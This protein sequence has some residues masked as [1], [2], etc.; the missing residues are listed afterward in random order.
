M[1]FIAASIMLFA[2][3]I[4]ILLTRKIEIRKT[5]YTNLFEY[6]ID[7]TN[8]EWAFAPKQVSFRMSKEDLLKEEQLSESAINRYDSSVIMNTE[9]IENVSR[10]LK[11]VPFVKRF[12]FEEEYGFQLQCLDYTFVVDKD[13][14]EE[15]CTLL[16]EQAQEYMP[17]PTFGTL[18]G[19]KNGQTV[20]WC[21]YAQKTNG[22]K[23][24]KSYVTVKVIDNYSVGGEFGVQLQIAVWHEYMTEYILNDCMDQ[25]KVDATHNKNFFEYAFE[26]E[27]LQISIVD[28]QI[29]KTY[30]HV[31][32]VSENVQELLFFTKKEFVKDTGFTDVEYS[33]IVHNED[34]EEVCEILYEQAQVYMQKSSIEDLEN[35]KSGIKTI[36]NLDAMEKRVEIISSD[37]YGLILG[38]KEIKIHLLY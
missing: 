21:E 10:T 9:I 2:I 33:I 12:S 26:P 11:N 13:S 23:I 1:L 25:I 38:G 29:E 36:L 34:F 3:V 16:M 8:E 37:Y 14:L 27:N 28:N 18:D 30:K 5:K 35:M 32:N 19:L 4:I 24:K 22:E 20:E 7:L 15:I 31:L 6:A 17:I